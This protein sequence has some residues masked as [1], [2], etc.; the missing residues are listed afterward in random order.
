[1][2]P[3]RTE[4]AGSPG[5]S[6]AGLL[7]R[8]G[9][10]LV[11]IL[12]GAAARAE[13]P[14]LFSETSTVVLLVGLPGDSESEG[15]YADQLRSWLEVLTGPGAPRKVFVLCDQPQA[16][17]VPS[18]VTVLAAN[19]TNFLSL[20]QTL[21]EGAAPILIVAWGH[22]GR[23]GAVPVLHVRGPRLTPDDFSTLRNAIP[24]SRWLLLFRGSGAFAH[25]LA[26]SG[27]EVLASEG[28][29]MFTSDPIGMSILLKLLRKE[30]QVPFEDL[31]RDFGRGTAAWYTER[32]LAR[33][34][35]PTLWVAGQKPQALAASSDDSASAG[36]ASATPGPDRTFGT[37]S[38][39]SPQTTTPARTTNS[40]SQALPPHWKQ[41]R[42][43]DPQQYPEADGVILRQTVTCVL[44]S[45]PALV[46]EQDEFLQ[47]LTAEGKKLGDFD[48]SFSPPAEEMEVLACEVLNPEGKLVRSDLDAIGETSD[49]PGGDYQGARRRFF[50][51]PGA[52]P[53]AVLH[54]HY[55]KQWKEFPLPR[56]SLALPLAQDL[57]VC[58]S[59]VKVTLPKQTP[60]HF[61]F[62]GVSAPDPVV[63]QTDYSTSY[64]WTFDGWPAPVHEVLSG[65]QEAPRLLLSTFQDWKAFAEW[66]ERL[67]RLTAEVTPE[68]EAKAR[69]LTQAAAS[70]EA[71]VRA[72]YEY[73]TGLRYVAVPMGVNSL[74]P[75]AA[76]NVLRN[77][78]GDCKDK[79]NLF[80]A[81]LRAV[82]IQGQ[83]VLVPRFSQA[84]ELVPGLAFNHAISRV[85]VGSQTLWF[86]TT[87][88]ICSFGLL[89]PGDPGRKVLVVDGAATNLTELSWTTPDQNRLEL[90]GEVDLSGSEA[91]SEARLTATAHGYPDYQLREA[92]RQHAEGQGAAPLLAS[93][94]RAVAGSFALDHQSLTPVSALAQ[95][96]SWRAEG[97]LLGISPSASGPRRIRSPVWIP[98]E[99]DL[100]LHRRRS[101]LYLN[102]GYPLAL[103]ENLVLRLPPNPEHVELPA[104]CEN[105][106][107]PLRWKV[108]WTR[109][110]DDKVA[111]GFRAELE[112]G[113]L[114]AAETAAF[115][116]QLRLLLVALSADATFSVSPNR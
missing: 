19:R 75:H 95:D 5:F 61:A 16:L 38:S 23:Q 85:S 45:S 79:A 34:E 109:V 31:A 92:A 115:Q 15:L 99:W 37:N 6:W 116:K 101:P 62:E 28:D 71:K 33:T 32:N 46:T 113:E 10:I 24:N 94:W 90:E 77:G 21:A 17:T 91:G 14:N 72:L 106:T 111:A 30:P 18:S 88:D 80:N 73:V 58:A 67:T 9:L 1:M 96:F 103:K 52:V 102:R 8:S 104:P 39:S 97:S 66:Y 56:I 43:V 59:T 86:D 11:F 107:S 12:G 63:Q 50:S 83:L 40:T 35:E 26:G 100:A 114:S 47:I 53:G 57:P 70:D 29:T 108:E 93:H 48:V 81:L 78:F 84:H 25:R 55:R 42:R 36:A 41:V 76:A 110:A 51:L 22:G 112:R 82:Q 54:I 65:P 60:F 69:E 98:K 49:A 64:V 7:V 74:R 3:T 89:P 87:D 20:N 68:I 105:V 2:T 44:G 4:R 27:A 13:Q